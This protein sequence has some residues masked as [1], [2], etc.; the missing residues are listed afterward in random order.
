MDGFINDV[1]FGIRMLIK[2]P[3]LSLIAIVAFALGI[4]LT[5]TVFSIVNG[6]M[7]KGLPFDDADRVV[8]V[9]RVNPEREIERG[10]VTLYDYVEY[11][12]QNSSLEAFGLW[13][14][15]AVNLVGADDKP[16][17]YQGARVTANMFEILRVAPVLGRGFLPEEEE[18]GAEPVM[19]IGYEVWQ[20]KF[21]GSP[22]VIGR[23]V[24]TNGEPRT[25]VGVA[26]EGFKFPIEAD[27][28]APL[29]VN[30]LEHDRDD[31]PQ[32]PGFGRLKPGVSL[33][34]ASADFATIGLRLEAEYPESNEGFSPIVEPFTKFTIGNELHALLF[35]MLGA[36]IGVLLIGCANVANLL[37]AR[38]AV[39]EKEVAVRS[40]I[41]AKRKQI[42]RQLLIEVGVLSAIGGAVGVLIGIAG[43]AWF[44]RAVATNPP[45]FWM[46]FDIDGRVLL[47][48]TLAS[49]LAA[50]AAGLFPALRATDKGLN[51]ALND[52]GRGS[53]SGLRMGRVT[54]AIVI[55]EVA[56]SCGLLIAAGLMIKSVAQLRTIDMPFAIE[57]IFTARL[58][59][60]ET[61]YPDA[62]ARTDFY[63]EF[64]QRLQTTPGIEAATLS[65]GLP[66]RGNGLRTFEIEGVD[67]PTERDYPRAREGIVTPGYFATFQA[68]VLE[69]RPF[70]FADTGDNLPVALVNRS[71]VREY[72]E[73]G[74]GIGKRFR[75]HQG[76]DVY[77]WMTVV[78]VVPDMKMEGI[79]NNDQSPAGYYIAVDQF[80]EILGNT[81]SVG[82]RTTGDPG[83]MAARVR[84]TLAALDPNLPVYD[85][86]SMQAVI[87][88]ATWFYRVFGTLF[89]TFG[90]TALFLAAVGLYGVMSFSVSQRRREMGIRMALGAKEDRLIRFAMR[91]GMRQLAI[92]IVIGIA[93]AALATKPLQ[94]ILYEVDARDPVIFGGVVLALALVGAIASYIPARR[95]SR[96]HPAEALQSG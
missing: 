95:V 58:N 19:I 28:W 54:S 5:T 85:A 72:F 53:S 82:A 49:G 18:P 30:P 81:V 24:R 83:A 74:V 90:F 9:W 89:M 43:M 42:V 39:R 8:S 33:D 79:G 65:D 20:E 37:F 1:K 38:A 26:P 68:P 34:R 31:G 35:T 50:V 51:E 61:D 13:S 67:Y 69:G 66:A 59:L 11:R 71:F 55:G 64:L 87:D 27:M 44:N 80:A 6:A 48:A 36:A 76:N 47:F 75:I 45:P 41:G 32:F 93:L 21:D 22:E 12:D 70:E 23:T 4:G 91:R 78:G 94:I 86:M 60:P 62:D 77:D 15:G 56:V 2:S 46:T 84:E 7:Y 16:E 52:E 14:N 10:G 96:I 57:N 88:D 92:G 3:V 29:E 25:I 40:A 63:R 17:R 73:D